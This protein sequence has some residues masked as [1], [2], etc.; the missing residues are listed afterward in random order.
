MLAAL[1]VVLVVVGSV[2]PAEVR[3]RLIGENGAIPVLGRGCGGGLVITAGG[4]PTAVPAAS[5][6]AAAKVPTPIPAAPKPAGNNGG[7]P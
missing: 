3:C 2:L 4:A 6:A 7:G 5:V 1:V